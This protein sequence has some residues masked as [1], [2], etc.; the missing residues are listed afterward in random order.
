MEFLNDIIP[1]KESQTPD[2]VVSFSLLVSRKPE[3]MKS[4]FWK[5]I[6]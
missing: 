2:E 1:C 5:V 6:E 4:A 3:E